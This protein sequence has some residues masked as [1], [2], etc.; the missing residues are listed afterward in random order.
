MTQINNHAERIIYLFIFIFAWLSCFISLVCSLSQMSPVL[1]GT[2]WWS[3]FQSG[4][5]AEVNREGGGVSKAEE[6]GALTAERCKVSNT[7]HR[8]RDRQFGF[9]LQ[10]SP[11]EKTL[12]APLV[13]PLLT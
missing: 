2:S 5:L 4:H 7:G 13:L 11:R 1:F 3:K 9:S 10:L 12:E 6:T 8:Q